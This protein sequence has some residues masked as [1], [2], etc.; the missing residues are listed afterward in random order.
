MPNE[1]FSRRQRRLQGE[2][3]HDVYQYDEIPNPL[4][5]KIQYI[6][7]A[8]WQNFHGDSRVEKNLEDIYGLGNGDS[9]MILEDIEN[10]HAHIFR[11]IDYNLRRQYGLISLISDQRF[12]SLPPS[13]CVWNF[14]FS[15]E[16]V[17][18]AIDVIELLFQ[19]LEDESCL[20]PRVIHGPF[21]SD[22]RTLL[23]KISMIFKEYK[24]EAIAE[25]HKEFQDEG[26]GYEYES[27][28]IIR[29]D[30][31]Y[32]H[33]KVVR[34]VLNLLSDPI[35]KNAN[36]EFLKAHKHYRKGEYKSCIQECSNAFESVL[37]II[38]DNKGW[39]CGERATAKPLLDTVYK[40]K[41][42]P[43]DTLPFFNNVR[44]ALESGI[45]NVRN[46]R[47]A[48]GQGSQ[49]IQVP[50]YM[51]EHLLNLTASSILLLSRANKKNT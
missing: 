36:E 51:A 17:E 10:W 11:S 35:Y 20:S 21:P 27:G 9:E 25:L 29:V 23:N 7:E 16:N 39:E 32:I 12:T 33:A 43:K 18:R 44:S 6:W 48:H 3:T 31:Q 13:Y 28:Q 8:L 15:T 5:I 24:K 14:F 50:N 26:I 49:E 4:R 42:L 46:A 2:F 19:H 40:N 41:L 34:P 22:I 47:A 30:S 1:I 38:C 45:P 37:K